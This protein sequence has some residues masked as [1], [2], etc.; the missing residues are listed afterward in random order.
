LWYLDEQCRKAGV[1]LKQCWFPGYHSDVGG[2]NDGQLDKSSIDEIAFAWMC[3]Q[4]H[5]L[6]QLSG[7]A[8]Q[9]TILFRIGESS[10]TKQQPKTER[11]SKQSSRKSI[12]WSDGELTETNSWTS[13]WWLASAVSTKRGSYVRRPGETKAKKIDDTAVHYSHFHEEIDPCVQHRMDHAK[14]GYESKSLRQP[15]W[16]RVE[17]ENGEGYEWVKKDDRENEILR[18]KEYAI[19]K[20]GPFYPSSGCD[21]WQG[22]LERAIAPRDNLQVLDKGNGA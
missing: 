10:Y 12:A 19:P 17:A 15:A 21:H 5:G 8:L 14:S 13:I 7:N 4:L 18:L 9:P 11:G 22:S 16:S 2:Y 3:D 20:I 1:N 6:L